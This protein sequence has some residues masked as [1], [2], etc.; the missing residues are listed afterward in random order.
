MRWL[1]IFAALVVAAIVA[2]KTV[3]PSVTV[4][5]RLTLE[6]QVDGEPKTGSGVIEVTYSKQSRFA[7]QRDLIVGYRGEAVVLDLGSRGILFALLKADTDNRS[8]PESIVLRAFNFPGGAF[9]G[10][11][12]EEGLKQL[13][14]LSGKRELPLTSLPLLVHFRGSNDP[15]TIERVDPLDFEK[16][17]GAGARLVR[18]TLEIVPA[19]I[20]PFNSYGLTGEPITRGI[21]AK[22]PWWNGPHPWLKPM[23]NGV[24]LDT[25]TESFKAN[26]ADFKRG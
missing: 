18:A 10:P 23:G 19:G 1:G 12:V 21:E 14:R 3:F 6:A 22:L 24:F 5:Y 20:W 4:R 7:G 17:F 2:Y 15:T 13:Q 8:I 11:S 26:K 9:P 25:R 16:S